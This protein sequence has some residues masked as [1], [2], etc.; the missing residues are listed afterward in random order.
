MIQSYIYE[1]HF[2]RFIVQ[3]KRGKYQGNYECFLDIDDF[4][5]VKDLPIS[6]VY[7]KLNKKNFYL[8][9]SL[10]FTD[11]NGKRKPKSVFLHR[12]IIEE[13][14]SSEDVDHE[15]H[16]TLDNRRKNL[17][18]TDHPHNTKNRKGANLNNKS[19]IRNVS[20]NKSYKKW[21]IQLQID[22]KNHVFKEKFDDKE[23]ARE[24]AEKM[25]IKYYGEFKGKG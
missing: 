2:V 23:D 22:G 18:I 20:W 8:A 16:N 6:V 7:R 14:K 4:E 15:N 13:L 10:R 5:K 9:I 17:R 3:R 1:E 25:R 19:G 21:V 12:Y 11:K 24:F